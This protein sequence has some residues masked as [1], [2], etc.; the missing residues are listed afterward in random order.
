MRAVA[1]FSVRHRRRGALQV[2][3]LLRLL[4]RSGVEAGDVAHA[5]L[6]ENLVALFHFIDHPAQGEEDL[7][8]I[9]HDR[10]DEMREC[11]VN[12]HLDHLGIDHDEAELIGRETEEHA[13]DER[14]DADALAAAG[15][16]GDEEM[17]HLREI[18]D[19]RF[20]VNVLAER[21]RQLGCARVPI[22]R[23]QAARG[24]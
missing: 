9:G 16:A 6:G 20:A 13:R 17:R 10:D 15:R 11:V 12:L 3:L 1:S 23:L 21:D 19:D 2:E 4:F 14:V 18:G 5:G 22:L 8:R 7:F 24:E